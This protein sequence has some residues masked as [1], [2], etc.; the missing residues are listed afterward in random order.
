MAQNWQELTRLTGGQ[1]MTVERVSLP[2]SGIAIEGSFELPPLAKLPM[3][4]QIFVAA[5]IRA[6]GSIK[7]TEEMFGVSYPT[8]KNRLKRIS[9]Q[10]EFVTI[11]AE[12]S[13]SEVLAM[14]ERGEISVEE[15]LERMGK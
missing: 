8:I 12:E 6:D 13:K 14:L 5:F 7:K 10:L 3:E 15:A 11:E 2:D 4:D 9:Q 1:E